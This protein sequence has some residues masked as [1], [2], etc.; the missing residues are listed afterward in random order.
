M[1][2]YVDGVDSPGG[3]FTLSFGG[4]STMHISWNASAGLV[5]AALESL[6]QV[7]DVTVTVD[8]AAGS[9]L[10]DLISKMAWL[11]EFTT[12][13]KP[14]NLGDLPLLGA[15]G[16]YLTGTKVSI[17]VEEVSTGCCAVEV[18]A[19]GGADYT[20]VTS[21]EQAGTTAFRYQERA[22]VRTVMPSAGPA[23]GGTQVLVSGTGFDLPSSASSSPDLGLTPADGDGMVCVFGEQLE[24]PAVRLNSTAVTCT[25]P[26]TSH[27]SSSAM[28]VTVRWP[29]SVLPSLTSAVFSYYEEVILQALDPRRGTNVGGYAT[30]VSIAS[31]S[32][33]AVAINVTC[34]VEVRLPSNSTEGYTAR[35][36]ITPAETVKRAA[37]NTGSRRVSSEEAYACSI[38]GIGDFF[39]GVSADHWLNGDWGAIALVRLSGNGGVDRSAPETFTYIPRP[40]ISAVEPALGEDGGGT[41]VIVHGARLAQPPE[42]FDDGEILCRFGHA[43]VVS[44][45]YISDD[46]IAC[47][48]PQHTNVPAVLSMVVESATVFHETQEV[49]LRAPSPMSNQ[50]NLV[51]SSLYG[52]WTLMLEGCESSTMNAN[53]TAADVSGA[54]SALP[55]IENVTVSAESNVFTDPQAGLSWNE[56]TYTVYFSARGGD[57]PPMSA[58]AANL[59]PSSFEETLA[60]AVNHEEN[61]AL[62]LAPTPQVVVN[63]VKDGH[64]GEMVEREV[65]VFRTARPALL[66]ETQ[67][68]TVA[69]G[70][71]PTAEVRGSAQIKLLSVIAGVT[72]N[73]GFRFG[74]DWPTT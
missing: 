13:G 9:V 68:I 16:S 35:E 20:N 27:L 26:P 22:V 44:A 11:I 66:A 12:L 7:G 39:S 2:R 8:P 51:S 50:G 3:S 55:N 71:P 29:G 19:N 23:A 34:T 41:S 43:P 74:P 62:V 65:Q 31:G 21:S 6:P 4:N 14:P 32:F 46:A 67:T 45:K 28:S 70:L 30:I 53:A 61:E 42:G 59:R 52:T 24:S 38:P 64:D 47:T 18:S 60:S 58:S 56:T 36:F 49:V 33:A 37:L 72:T 25:S 57:I 63:T 15:D 17:V 73:L 1:Y 10:G 48:I 40:S 69:T 5:E 54:L